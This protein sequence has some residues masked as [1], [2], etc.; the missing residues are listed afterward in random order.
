[1]RAHDQPVAVPFAGETQH[2]PVPRTV[3]EVAAALLQL[4]PVAGHAD[5]ARPRAAEPGRV[6]G[7]S[8]D[9]ARGHRLEGGLG[10]EQDGRDAHAPDPTA[11]ERTDASGFTMILSPMLRGTGVP[12]RWFSR[13]R[14]TRRFR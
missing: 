2:P 9:P 14:H 5:L 10:D 12:V 1:A 7:L 6:G 11:G 8:V 13:R 4:D 3:D